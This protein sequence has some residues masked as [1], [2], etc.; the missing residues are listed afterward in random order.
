MSSRE[1]RNAAYFASRA[2]SMRALDWSSSTSSICPVRW[3]AQSS[4]H[5]SPDSTRN[6]ARGFLRMR[7]TFLVR[8]GAT[9]QMVRSM[10]ANQIGRVMGVPSPFS[11]V[12]IPVC[13]RASTSHVSS[14]ESRML[15]VSSYGRSPGADGRRLEVEEALGVGAGELQNVVVGHIAELLSDDL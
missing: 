10:A 11:V 6:D 2:A 3:T 13:D 4:A 15:M 9:K 7:L 1:V 5:R 8:L 12:R 14:G